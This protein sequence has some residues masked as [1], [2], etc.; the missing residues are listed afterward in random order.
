MSEASLL[1]G[2]SGVPRSLTGASTED[3][4]REIARLELGAMELAFGHRV[5][6]SADRAPEI[7]R[8]AQEVG[9]ALSAHASYYINL[10]S[11][12]ARKV[13]ASRQRILQAARIGYLCGATDIVFHA[14]WR[15]DDPPEQVSA[16]VREHLIELSGILADEKVEVC[17]RPETTGKVAQF[18]D[19]DELVELAHDIPNVHPCIDFAHLHARDGG[20]NREEEFEGILDFVERSLGRTPM[21][22]H[23]SG[24]KYG[25]RGE[26]S[27]LLL[28]ESDFNYQGLLR[29]LRERCVQGRVIC[30]SPANDA[31]AVKLNRI[32]SDG[33]SHC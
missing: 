5:N 25:A 31:D 27:H 15:H 9:V 21:H 18:G 24:I 32:W 3:G 8:L 17:L 30:E 12:D 1:F 10:N 23:V 26:Q 13:K 29:V 19:L 22:L 16:T 6:I 28:D 4:I 11:H 14:A 20:A 33:A 7:K 2:T